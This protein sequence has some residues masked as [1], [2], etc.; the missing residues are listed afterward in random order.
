M[1]RRV[2]AAIALLFSLTAPAT[3]QSPSQA[4][5]GNW[6]GGWTS[7]LDF[8]NPNT[9]SHGSPSGIRK[10]VKFYADGRY[11]HDELDQTSAYGCQTG[12]FGADVGRFS[13]DGDVIHIAI[14]KS[15]LHQWSTCSGRDF[16]K[17]IDP[18]RHSGSLRWRVM[19]KDGYHYLVLTQ[20][21]G[22]PYGVFRSIKRTPA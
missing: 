15:R 16:W 3:A 17:D 14:A 9:G 11:E 7:T 12:Y 4:L 8:V 6:E 21:N 1:Q 20:I 19:D 10:A 18:R 2:I 22:Q 5:V 13:V